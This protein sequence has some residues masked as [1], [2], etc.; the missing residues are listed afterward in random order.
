MTER[1]A[2]GLVEEKIGL[3]M[4]KLTCYRVCSDGYVEIVRESKCKTKASA[5]RIVVVSRSSLGPEFL[6]DKNDLEQKNY[7]IPYKNKLVLI[8]L[9]D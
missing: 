2:A 8:P 3:D 7:K 4:V 1:Y 9:L 6:L 5:F